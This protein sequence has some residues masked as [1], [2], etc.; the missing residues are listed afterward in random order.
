MKLVLMYGRYGK[1]NTMVPIY[2]KVT[3]F[4][5]FHNINRVIL[6]RGLELLS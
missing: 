6:E 5:F 1:I 3:T 2:A 4:I